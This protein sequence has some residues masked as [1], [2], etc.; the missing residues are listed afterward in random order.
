MS[1]SKPPPSAPPPV[2]TTQAAPPR[3]G[4]QL[5]IADFAKVELRVGAHQGRGEDRGLEEAPEA[6]GGPGHRD[7][8]DRGR[9]RRGL[10]A[11]GARGQEDRAVVANLKPAKL[12]GV[13]SQRHGAGGLAGRQGRPLHVRRRRPARHEDQVT[14]GSALAA[15]RRVVRCALC[16]AGLAAVSAAPGPQ[17]RRLRPRRAGCRSPSAGRRARSCCSERRRPSRTW[18]RASTARRGA[19]AIPSLGEG[20][21]RAVA[22]LA[23]AGGAGGGRRPGALP[24]ASRD[25]G[26]GRLNGAPVGAL[27][28]QRRPPPLPAVAC[29]PR[30]RG[31]ARTGCASCSRPPPS[32]ADSIRG[33]ADQRQLA[34]AFHS[35]TVGAAGDAGLDDL[36]ARDAPAPFAVI[37][38]GRRARRRA[39]RR[40]A[41]CATRCGCPPG[42]ELRFTPDLHPAAR[43]GGGAASLRVTVEARPGEERELWSRVLGAR[44]GAAGRG[45]GRAAGR[46]GRHRAARPARGRRAGRP[47]RLGRVDRAARPGPGRRRPARAGRRVARSARARPSSLRQALARRQRGAPHPR[48]GAGASSSAATA[49]AAADDAGDRPHR[50]GGRRVRARL[51]AGRLHAGRDVVGLDVAVSRPPPRARCPS[52]DAC[53]R[54]A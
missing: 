3:R 31:R 39:D 12:M 9:H 50:R 17:G 42:A 47:L 52:R 8:A 41:S 35:L 37:D 40:P 34:A 18:P 4:R 36:L 14:R 32:P 16:P 6:R 33:N 19:R 7:A 10:R 49:T 13:E 48:R 46:R 22:H 54:T 23:A 27:R 53:P 28:A 5:D 51:H 21:G 44:D 26:R 25:S 11:R 30:R 29:P 38:A 24:R 43:R 1:D 15:H 2:A 45:R 20:R